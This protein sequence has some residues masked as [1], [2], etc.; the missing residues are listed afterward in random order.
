METW[1]PS[2]DEAD[3]WY[4]GT[5]LSREQETVKL[6]RKDRHLNRVPDHNGLLQLACHA[7]EVWD[8]HPEGSRLTVCTAV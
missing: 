5:S 6:I 7:P 3:D 8:R 1:I 2:E 4:G